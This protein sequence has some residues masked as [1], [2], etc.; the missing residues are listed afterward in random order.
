MNILLFEKNEIHSDA[1]QLLSNQGCTIIDAENNSVDHQSIETVFIRT[2][3]QINSA[4]LDTYPNLKYI[5]RAGVGIDN[6]DTTECQIRNIQIF[7][8]PGANAHSVAELGLCFIILMLR[9]IE[10]QIQSLKNN[11]WRKRQYLGS[12]VKG[13]TVGIIG[14][15]AVGKLLAKKLTGFEVKSILGYDPFLTTEQL[16]A[17]NIIKAEL[18]ELLSHSDVI[19]LCIP[20][21]LET[22]KLIKIE[23]LQKMKN[24]SY[25]VNLSRG[26]IIDEDHLIHAL[27]NN[28]IAGAAL[29]VFE[30]E[31]HNINQK[32][33]TCKNLVVTPHIGGFTKEGDR[34][35]C[36]AAAQ[37]FLNNFKKN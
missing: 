28:I 37:N 6:I 27:Q 36:T 25:I 15:G 11:D 35:I 1:L 8:S 14:C 5:I 24:T 12:E 33:L 23:H 13:K 21:T 19:V 18:D 16:Y 34:Q 7:N 31:P 3:T 22:Y 2:Y 32:L 17:H 30:N 9:N 20:L 10:L 29:D 26:G 4:F